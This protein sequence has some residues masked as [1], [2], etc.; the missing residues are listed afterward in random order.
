M[1]YSPYGAREKRHRA[2]HL[3]RRPA[4][5][6]WAGRGR[7][8]RAAS[9]VTTPRT[10]RPARRA[11]L[12]GYRTRARAYRTGLRAWAAWRQQL[13]VH[14]F[15]TRRHR[16]D[17]WSTTPRPS[18]W[19]RT[20]GPMPRRPSSAGFGDPPLSDY[21]ISVWSSPSPRVGNVRL[22]V[23]HEAATHRAQQRP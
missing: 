21:G 4:G 11:I 15:D 1:S 17:A 13:D 22:R 12:L 5:Q 9:G 8:G 19:P 6:A 7:R 20:G 10:V 23:Y 16:V 18:R 14:R 3:D 2:G